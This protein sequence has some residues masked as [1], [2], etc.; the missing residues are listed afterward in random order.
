MCIMHIIQVRE[1]TTWCG[2]PELS[3]PQ[4]NATRELLHKVM[5]MDEP[6]DGQTKQVSEQRLIVKWSSSNKH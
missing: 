3:L 4:D 5:L 1:L 2:E 6:E